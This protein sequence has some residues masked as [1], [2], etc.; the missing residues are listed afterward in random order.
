MRSRVATLL[1]FLATCADAASLELFEDT[2]T[3]ATGKTATALIVPADAYGIE[4]HAT[5]A[6]GQR[7]EVTGSLALVTSQTEAPYRAA[8]GVSVVEGDWI[9]TAQCLSAYE[10]VVTCRWLEE[11]T[12]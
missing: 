6:T 4:C 11:V 3:C 2:A 12:P 8:Y 1:L 7:S 5:S 10:P 9:M